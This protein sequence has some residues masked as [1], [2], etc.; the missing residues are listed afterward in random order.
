MDK[1]NGR[2]SHSRGKTE[3][4][5]GESQGYINFDTKLFI[6][7]ALW[8]SYLSVSCPLGQMQMGT[9]MCFVK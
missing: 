4:L 1:K 9:M 3:L 6:H 5:K 2:R 7:I 8:T